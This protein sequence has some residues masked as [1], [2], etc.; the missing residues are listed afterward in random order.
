[1]SSACD[2]EYYNITPLSDSY[3]GLQPSTPTAVGVLKKILKQ[4]RIHSAT[5]FA[6][7][8]L[9]LTVNYMAVHKSLYF[10]LAD[11]GAAISGSNKL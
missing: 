1:M 3:P 11:F 5:Y 7:D 10:R 4:L 8:A 9:Y 2:T 6:E